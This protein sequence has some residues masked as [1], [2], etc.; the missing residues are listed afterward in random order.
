MSFDEIFD[1]TAG[2]YFNFYNIW[3]VISRMPC[4]EICQFAV[5]PV[6]L[7]CALNHRPVSKRDTRDAPAIEVGH[8]LPCSQSQIYYR[9]PCTSR[10]LWL[11]STSSINAAPPYSTSSIQL[12]RV[13][14]T[15]HAK[16][17]TK[18][19]NFRCKISVPARVINPRPRTQ[20]VSIHWW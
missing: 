12:V 14:V 5:R 9:V 8:I 7:E 11:L 10:I 19:H 1:L 18:F 20:N 16:F 6:T 13:S 3:W 2:V 15:M 17:K 4:R